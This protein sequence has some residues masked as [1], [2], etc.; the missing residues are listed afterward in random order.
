M[1]LNFAKR[2]ASEPPKK[3]DDADPPKEKKRSCHEF[4]KSGTCS[5]GDDCAY[6]HVAAAPEVARKNKQV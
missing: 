1:A 2:S 5:K 3:T 4:K 6:D